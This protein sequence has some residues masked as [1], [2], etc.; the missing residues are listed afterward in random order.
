MKT[1]QRFFIKD[2]SQLTYLTKLRSKA[3]LVLIFTAVILIIIQAAAIS[4]LLG[5]EYYIANSLLMSAALMLVLITGLLAMRYFAFSVAGS[6]VVTTFLITHLALLF[7]KNYG[8]DEFIINFSGNLYISIGTIVLSV[9]FSTR[10][11]LLVNA[12]L[13][14]AAASFLY[15]MGLNKV[16]NQTKDILTSSFTLILASVIIITIILYFSLSFTSKAQKSTL[17]FAKKVKTQDEQN[18]N[19]LQT[20]RRVIDGQQDFTTEL[21][22][23]VGGLSSSTSTQ[24]A[25]LEEIS[26]TLEEI[27]SSAEQNAQQAQRI[28]EF[29][30]DTSKT[31][32]QSGSALEKSSRSIAEVT[33]Y[34]KIIEEIAFQTK[35][36]SLNAS[37]QAAKAGEH[38]KGFSAVAT[39]IQ[40]L[41]QR[42]RT[43]ASQ[44]HEQIAKNDKAG[45]ELNTKL[46]AIIKSIAEAAEGAE[47]IAQ[48]A[49]QQRTGTAQ[50]SQS[51]AQVN[52]SAQT[53]AGLAEQI[54]NLQN[55]LNKETKELKTL[56][57]RDAVIS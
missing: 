34:I 29:I 36:L 42:S 3:L 5:T 13:F 32:E 28:N 16:D 12:L 24:A 9:L 2:Y 40:K 22:Q 50:V 44:I 31:A 38:G 10:K 57:D 35:L 46:E 52:K 53:N 51:T 4:F 56:L 47:N 25:D 11:M 48:S 33:E 1:I 55:R 19:L 45:A 20:I 37:I 41:S 17:D 54:N 39:E 8:A 21:S 18:Q 26:A 43:A 15:Y 14:I 27:D 30:K 49:E 23:A 7:T 6:Y